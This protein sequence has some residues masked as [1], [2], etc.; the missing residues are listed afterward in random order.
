M[1]LVV[2][3]TGLYVR[4]LF[5]GLFEEPPLDRDRR[6]RARGDRSESC[7]VDE[8]RRWVETLDSARAHLGRTQLIRA[9]EIALLTGHRVSDLHRDRATVPRWRPRYLVVDPGPSLA[10]P[11]RRADRRHARPRVA[12]RGARA[13]ADGTSGRHRRGTRPGMTRC[14]AWFA[15]TSARSAAHEEILIATRQYAKRQRTWF[16]HQLPA[17]RRDAPRP[18]LARLADRGSELGAE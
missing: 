18:T 3:G 15:A 5:E 2:G 9:I 16:R 6:S 17:R 8:L 11:N 13:D 4:A 10:A 7:T 1:P 12:R 14:G